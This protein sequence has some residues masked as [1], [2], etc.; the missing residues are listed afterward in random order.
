EEEEDDGNKN[1]PPHV[2]NANIGNLGVDNNNAAKADANAHN[3]PGNKK[4]RLATK[5][6]NDIKRIIPTKFDGT[7]LRDGAENWLSKME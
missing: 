6:T 4:E 5:L 1:K 3:Q 2:D 7:T